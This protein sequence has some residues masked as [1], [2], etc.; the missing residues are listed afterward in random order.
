MKSNGL[1]SREDSPRTGP[2]GEEMLE[3]KNKKQKPTNI[4]KAAKE[5]CLQGESRNNQKHAN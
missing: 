5:Q 1:R 4:E 2:L 3:R